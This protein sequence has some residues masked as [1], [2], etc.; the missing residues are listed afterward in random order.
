MS[1]SSTCVRCQTVC[2]TKSKYVCKCYSCCLHTIKYKMTV[3]TSFFF[4]ST[5]VTTTRVARDIMDIN[6]IS[7]MMHVR[8]RICHGKYR[9][10]R[11]QLCGRD[12]F[13]CGCAYWS[14]RSVLINA[15]SRDIISVLRPSVLEHWLNTSVR[16]TTLPHCHCAVSI[17]RL[18]FIRIN[19]IV[20]YVCARLKCKVF[21]CVCANHILALRT[22]VPSEWISIP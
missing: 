21:L 13:L 16:V 7:L 14:V 18:S 5:F 10:S 8:A 15:L 3:V 11:S 22:D 12:T 17:D 6:R 2:H 4:L 9:S 1:S 20:R 19:V